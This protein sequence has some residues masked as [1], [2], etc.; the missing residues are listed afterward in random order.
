[1]DV[2]LAPGQQ[3]R[4]CPRAHCTHHCPVRNHKQNLTQAPSSARRLQ[5]RLKPQASSGAFTEP[6]AHNAGPH[7][8][9]LRGGICATEYMRPEAPTCT[10]PLSSV[11]RSDLLLD[12]SCGQGQG[13]THQL[14][15]R[16][17]E[18]TNPP[19]PT[20]PPLCISSKQHL[21]KQT[22]QATFRAL[23]PPHPHPLFLRS[24][25]PLCLHALSAALPKERLTSHLSCRAVPFPKPPLL[26]LHVSPALAS[27]PHA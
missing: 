16:A 17:C 18:A 22:K 12:S 23:Q 1:M 21:R 13:Q 4:C 14:P 24:P 2:K 26:F 27:G 5:P 8:K 20:P 7:R 19:H 10:S 6:S 25:T 11:K 9:S 15:A 3:A